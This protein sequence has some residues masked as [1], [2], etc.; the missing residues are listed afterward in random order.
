[1]TTNRP[2][3]LLHELAIRTLYIEVKER[4]NAAG[5]LLPALPARS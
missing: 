1:M 3:Y 2:L 5:K 4:A